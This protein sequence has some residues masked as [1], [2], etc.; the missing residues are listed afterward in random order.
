MGPKR[1]VVISGLSGAGKTEALHTLEDTG[2]YCVD[3]LP[4]GFLAEFAGEVAA[5]RW[6]GYQQVAVGID[7]RSA[8]E[9]LTGLPPALR[10]LKSAAL[11]VELVFIEA[12]DE[13]LLKRFSETRRRHP[14]SGESLPLPGAIAAERE[15]L[16]PL[17]E[18]ADLRVDTSAMHVH[19][20]REWVRERVA[21]RVVGRLSLQLLS[22]GYKNGVP[23]E[24]DFVF[25]AR[26]LPNPHWEA[27]LRD[28]S[29]L[30]AEVRAFLDASPLAQELAEQIG[31]FMLAWIPRFEAEDRPYLTVA[32]GCTG[33][34]HRSVYVTERL[35]ESLRDG[36][37]AVLISHRDL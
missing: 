14:L 7:A 12:S 31:R 33:G 36:G 21:R 16:A 37:R 25:D 35:A 10:Q 4:L 29:G 13:I 1:L 17:A 2:F 5:S 27:E 8:V 23:P 28:R 30:D 22:F 18:Y 15:R 20:L 9:N 34:R 24:S 6:P 32:V 19:R 26:G 11:A 3:N